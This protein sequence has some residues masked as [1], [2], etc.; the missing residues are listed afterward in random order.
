M[1]TRLR[2]KFMTENKEKAI[3]LIFSNG[4]Q[5]HGRL[6]DYDDFYMLIDTQAYNSDPVVIPYSAVSAYVPSKR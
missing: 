4:F 6:V 5:L 2:D 1:E 3:R